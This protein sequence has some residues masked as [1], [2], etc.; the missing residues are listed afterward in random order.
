MQLS[1]PPRQRVM[2]KRDFK[3]EK[4]TNDRK[5]NSETAPA[6]G[7]APAAPRPEQHAGSRAL[8]C[9]GAVG[10]PRRPH[11]GVRRQDQHL[12][13]LLL[14]LGRLLLRQRGVE[15]HLHHGG[16]CTGRRGERKGARRRRLP[17]A[18]TPPDPQLLPRPSVRRRRRTRSGEAGRGRSSALTAPCGGRALSPAGRP[19]PPQSRAPT[20]SSGTE[21]GRWENY[22][23]LVHP[24]FLKY[25]HQ[26]GRGYYKELYFL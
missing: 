14:L 26:E 24:V 22:L 5:T 17:A 21:N 12:A 1:L 23:N 6:C 2:A 19:R 13:V 25:F 4:K 18:P 20:R 15:R 3:K 16:Y 7:R 8:R 10:R 11:L 9:P